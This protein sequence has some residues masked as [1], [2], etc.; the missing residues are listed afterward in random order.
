M[1]KKADFQATAWLHRMV[2][3][4]LYEGA[5]GVDATMGNGQD[6]EFLCRSVGEKG[7]VTA[8]DIQPDAVARTRERLAGQGWENAS[9]ILGS[10]VHMADCL[11]AESVDLILFNLGYLPGGDHQICTKAETTIPALKTALTLLKKGGAI[12]LLIYSGGDTGTAEKDAV[13]QWLQALN[14]RQYLVITNEFY[15][16]PNNPPLPVLVVKLP[17]E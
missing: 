8:F 13:L 16:R 14:P 7:R 2:G 3:E 1:L 15:N 6:T 4:F 5:V 12:G 17:E 9:L 10:H 11:E